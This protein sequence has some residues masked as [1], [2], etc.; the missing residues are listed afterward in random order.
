MR[1]FILVFVDPETLEVSGTLLAAPKSFTADQVQ[2]LYLSR[3]R[4]IGEHDVA[5]LIEDNGSLH[6]LE[7]AEFFPDSKT[8]RIEQPLDPLQVFALGDWPPPV[9]LDLPD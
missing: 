9:D 4:S 8:V 3:L 6:E 7:R 5:A 1:I 2:L